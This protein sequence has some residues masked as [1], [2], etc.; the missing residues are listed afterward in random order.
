MRFLNKILDSRKIQLIF[1]QTDARELYQMDRS[2]FNSLTEEVKSLLGYFIPYKIV[3]G[4]RIPSKQT[5]SNPKVISLKLNGEGTR[6][7]YELNGQLHELE[8]DGRI[9]EVSVYNYVRT[10]LQNKKF[11]ISNETIELNKAKQQ[12]LCYLKKNNKIVIHDEFLREFQQ[13]IDNI[14]EISTA[15]AECISEMKTI[16]ESKDESDE[17]MEEIMRLQEKLKT[18]TGEV[19]ASANSVVKDAKGSEN[20]KQNQEQQFKESNFYPFEKK[21]PE[22]SE[23][24]KRIFEILDMQKYT[25]G[26]DSNI[27]IALKRIGL[28]EDSIKK[29]KTYRIA[30]TNQNNNDVEVSGGAWY[31]DD[32]MNSCGKVLERFGVSLERQ[33]SNMLTE[34]CIAN[35]PTIELLQENCPRYICFNIGGNVTKNNSGRHWIA[36]VL[37]KK[38]GKVILLYKDSLGDFQ[39]MSG[40]IENSFRRHYG[41]NLK[42]IKNQAIEQLDDGSCGPMAV[43][44]LKI[45]AQKIHDYDKKGIDGIAELI[46]GEFKTMAFTSQNEVEEIRMLH[47]MLNVSQC[48]AINYSDSGYCSLE[49]IVDQVCLSSQIEDDFDVDDNET[50]F[51]Q[52]EGIK[53]DVMM[54]D[55]CYNECKDWNDQTLRSW[56]KDYK[57]KLAK[58]FDTPESKKDLLKVIA[59]MDRANQIA[60]GGHRFLPAQKCSILI[61][62]QSD[63]QGHVSQINTG[64]GK[65]TIVSVLSALRVMQGF[66]THVITSNTVLASDGVEKKALFYKLLSISV[67]DNNP[68]ASYV[69]GPRKC[70]DSDVVYGCI[71]SFQFD[72]LRHSFEQLKTMG[73]SGNEIDFNNIWVMLDEIDSLL[74]DQGGNIAKLSGPFPGMESLRYV[75]INIWI[76]LAAAEEKISEEMADKLRSKSETLDKIPSS[77][78][79]DELKQSEFD[80][81]K[82]QLGESFLENVKNEVN[83]Q[84]NSLINK[85]IIASHLHKYAD[86]SIER[87]VDFAFAA[88][89]HY[90]ENVEYRI[91]KDEKGEKIITPV[92]NQNTGVSMQNTIL[93]NGLHQFLQLKHN[94]CLTYESLTSCYI[95]NLDYIR[96]YGN[97]LSGVTGTLGSKPEQNLLG[98]VFAL[99]FSVVP[100]S[101]QK[102]FIRFPGKVSIDEN[103]ANDVAIAALGE[104][105]RTKNGKE[106]ADPRAVLIICRSIFDAE[107]IIEE[108]KSE[109]IAADLKYQLHKYVDESQVC[110]TQKTLRPGDIVVATNL[111]GRGTDFNT[112]K[113]LEENGG[114][115]VIEAFLPCNKRVED[116]GMGRTCRQGNKGTGQIIVRLSE[117]EALKNET[118][119]DID[120]FDE[121]MDSRDF[122]EEMRVNDIAANKIKELEFKGALFEKFSNC[123]S[124]VKREHKQGASDDFVKWIYVLRDLK[125]KWAFWLENQNY[126]ADRI[127]TLLS[128]NSCESVVG[129]EY[130]RFSDE[131][132]AIIKGNINHNPFYSICLAEKYLDDCNDKA[133]RQKAKNALCHAI[134]LS[135]DSKLLYSAYIKLFE[136]AIDNGQ[137]I[138]KRY[139]KAVADIFFYPLDQDED[140]EYKKDALSNL[141]KARDALKLEYDY[142]ESIIESANSE[143][144]KSKNSK[145]EGLGRILIQTDDKN[146]F[147][148]HL[149]S[150]FLC[151]AAFQ[152][153]VE[154]LIR[155]L[156]GGDEFED[157]QDKINPNDGIVMDSKVPRYLAN[158][159]K[160]DPIKDLITDDSV[161]EFEY[162]GMNCVYQLRKVHDIPSTVL[163]GAK[164][165]IIG[166]VALL[167]SAYAFPVLLPVNGPLAGAMISEGITDIITAFINQGQ[168]KFDKKDYIKGKVISYGITIATMGIGALM[169]STK[170]LNKAMNACRKLADKLRSV[171]GPFR[172]VCNFLAKQLDKIANYLEKTI[173]HIQFLQKSFAEQ[174]KYLDNLKVL[175][176]TDKLKRFQQLQKVYKASD[177]VVRTGAMISQVVK[178]SVIGSVQGVA[179][180]IA[181][182]RIVIAGL[183]Q[184]M[185]RLQPIIEEKVRKSVDHKIQM[186]YKKDKLNHKSNDQIEKALTNLMTTNLSED[187]GHVSKEIGLGLLRYSQNWKA[188]LCTLTLET[189]LTGYDVVTSTEKVCEK[190]VGSLRDDCKNHTI[191]RDMIDKIVKN[192][193]GQISSAM[194]G[195]IVAITGKIVTTVPKALY[196]AHQNR[197]EKKRDAEAVDKINQKLGDIQ[198]ADEAAKLADMKCS[199]DAVAET[200][201]LDPKKLSD[202]ANLAPSDKG[203]NIEDTK[204]LYTQNGIEVTTSNADNAQAE[205]A[206]QKSDRGVVCLHK[207]GEKFGH[208]VPVTV[209][210]GKLMVQEN[211]KSIPFDQYKRDNKYNQSEFI[212]PKNLNSETLAAAQL[213]CRRNVILRATHTVDYA[214]RQSNGSDILYGKQKSKKIIGIGELDSDSTVIENKR[215][216]KSPKYHINK[217]AESFIPKIGALAQYIRDKTGIEPFVEGPPQ[218]QDRVGTKE[219][220]ASHL[221]RV[222]VNEELK[223]KHPDLYKKA[224][225]LIARTHLVDTTYNQGFI[226]RKFDKWQSKIVEQFKNF[227]FSKK[228]LTKAEEDNMRS[229]FKYLTDG[230]NKYPKNLKPDKVSFIRALT[231]VFNSFTTADYQNMKQTAYDKYQAHNAN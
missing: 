225:E 217:R 76:A 173:E 38:G 39:N 141:E 153:N 184:M 36:M 84:K 100:P 186:E 49:T 170:V 47:L 218:S 25:K 114:L 121:V 42:M 90:S 196:Q 64:E 134:K 35:L 26:R 224:E 57:G 209:E 37:V 30:V 7:C 41:D 216:I 31:T 190:F 137:Q 115:H 145:I 130:K 161:D 150:R 94:L 195:K 74:I 205:F 132:D 111:A 109:S 78:K 89:H 112:S 118:E 95:S 142:L 65:T 11:E 40:R 119:D 147:M 231:T 56:S 212:V 166:A 126:T 165:Q 86:D 177:N 133:I 171:E 98:R 194:Y 124:Q 206:K 175:N 88:K 172:K 151:L 120:D 69:D 23:K 199:H 19:V 178:K 28:R 223:K 174:T 87:W 27:E 53:Q 80:N 159:D 104:M 17:K 102:Q 176:D 50:V 185:S 157:K 105:M 122:L 213:N 198:K 143:S 48:E 220:N 148:T 204:R 146:I 51:K 2:R 200:L 15:L 116:Q 131:A 135:G 221:Y 20:Q 21:F 155:Q 96:K 138:L 29:L 79:S 61:F 125:E 215:K 97:K 91:G 14:P 180:S 1:H 72:W 117:V 127:R 167:T 210:N 3:F 227:D 203:A 169:S 24:M 43:N 188:Q 222:K 207:D 62:M 154:S 45:L 152:G 183:N 189:A 179:M 70:Y 228:D 22:Q 46:N 101:K 160:T 9:F 149:R 156:Q 32:M 192:L 67:S 4:G 197:Q 5:Q 229:I 182:E 82:N 187:I 55:K 73:D 110:V 123:Y 44:N 68:D 214:G 77:E 60:T 99:T 168:N 18:M 162:V 164:G 81:F 139:K 59:I 66:K 191:S 230:L 85:A 103:F 128:K 201:G 106:E 52:K 58:T 163:N 208:T 13:F 63:S 108:L 93:S 113:E 158:L 75:Y 6:L 8:N 16:A 226:G 144:D 129:Q 54:I 34:D 107:M 83:A 193:S 219:N 202:A 92:D 140:N 12:I 211:G 33:F 71:T 136:I 10:E 181:M